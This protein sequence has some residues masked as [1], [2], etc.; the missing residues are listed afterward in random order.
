MSSI[1]M[2]LLLTLL[3]FMAGFGLL[4]L[5]N[6]RLKPGMSASLSVLMGI[7]VF[8]FITFL[9]QLF[10][11]PLTST[12]I[13]AALIISS[14]LLNIK[15]K[16]GIARLNGLIKETN[17]NIRLYELPFLLVIAF[18]IFV[19]IWRCF[20]FPPTSRDVTSG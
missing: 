13:F 18:I 15:F 3:Q 4:T 14:L 7:A 19:S 10:Y 9:L 17:F 16:T 6:I 2:I 11:L 5:F 20:Y 8:S 1:L 12:N